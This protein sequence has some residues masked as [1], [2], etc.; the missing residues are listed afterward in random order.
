MESN[1]RP[2]MANK[3]L[4]VCIKDMMQRWPKQLAA[5]LKKCPSFFTCGY[6]GV[7]RH[8]WR[9]PLTDELLCKEAARNEQLA[10]EC[11]AA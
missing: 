9:Y 8:F 2:L 1:S 3:M 5:T 7:C 6:T 4:S 10:Q 11:R